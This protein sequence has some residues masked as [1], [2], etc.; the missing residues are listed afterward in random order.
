[1]AKVDGRPLR[2]GNG[3]VFGVLAERLGVKLNE[4]WN[5]SKDVKS[6]IKYAE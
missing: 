5:E 2:G 1:M 3:R 6:E 4:M